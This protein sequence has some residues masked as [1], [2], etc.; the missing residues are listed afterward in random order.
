GVGPLLEVRVMGDTAFE[1]DRVV[2]GAAESL[3]DD[4]VAAL[5]VLDGVGR[6]LEG[7]DLADTR[8]RR[9]LVAEVDQEAERLVRVEARRIDGELLAHYSLLS[10]VSSLSRGESDGVFRDSIPQKGGSLSAPF[11]GLAAQRCRPVLQDG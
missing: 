10:S 9:C 3:E 2:L 8:H 5:L 1:G 6:P 11:T 4:R 7:A